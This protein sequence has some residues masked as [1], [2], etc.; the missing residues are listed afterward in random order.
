V[1]PAANCRTDAGAAGYLYG[2]QVSIYPDGHDNSYYEEPDAFRSWGAL[3]AGAVAGTDSAGRPLVRLTVTRPAVVPV[4]FGP[5]CRTP[6]IVFDPASEGDRVDF[7]T[8]ENCLS[9][10]GD[11]YLRYTTVTATPVSGDPSLAISGWS[12]DGAPAPELGTGDLTVTIDPD[13]PA[14]TASMVHCYTV[15]VGI[16]GVTDR[17]NEATGAVRIDG[18][19]CPDGG[20]RYVGGTEVTLTPQILAAG[21]RFNGWDEQRIKP[22][23]PAGGDTGDVTQSARTLVLEGDIR[24]TAGFFDQS[25]CSP[26]TNIGSP[27]LISFEFTGCGPGYYLDDRKQQAAIEGIEASQLTGGKYLSTLRANVHK[28]GALDVYVSI[29]AESPDCNKGDT[30]D[31]EGFAF[32]GPRSGT[33]QCRVSGPVTVDASVCQPVVTDPSFTVAGRPGTTY[34]REW[35]PDTFYVTGPDGYIRGVADYQWGQALPVKPVAGGKYQLAVTSGP[36]A[37]GTNLFAPNTDVLVYASAPSQGFS[38]VGWTGYGPDPVPQTPLHKITDDTAKTLPGSASYL[39]ACH[40]VTF[41]EG[42]HVLADAPYCPGSTPIERSFIFGMSIPVRADY[43]IGDRTIEKFTY[44]VAADQISQDPATLDW[45]GYA[46]VGVGTK[47]TALYQSSADR[48]STEIAKGLKFGAGIVAVVLP[49]VLGTAFP[50]LGMFFAAM[51]TIA[52]ISSF[53]PGGQGA[54]AVFDLLNPTKIT[55]CIARWGFTNAGSPGGQKNIGSMISTGKTIGQAVFTTKDLL[56]F[57]L[58]ILGVAGGAASI[59][60]GLYD[61]GIGGANMVGPQSVEELAGRSTITGCLDD[62]WR[63]TGSNLSRSG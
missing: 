33:V 9:P 35:M 54:A 63:I 41:G 60:Y 25:A 20:D 62:V 17:Y 27:G 58:G 61:A 23:K 26:L 40:T 57:D 10:T 22:E 21:T 52:G 16:D 46:T 3:P 14:Y 15:E 56:T 38:F 43:R 19:K 8:A 24:T 1:Y 4:T 45:Y 5:V 55:G 39:V 34:G 53:I 36:C 42:I 6:D 37:A 13:S 2:T 30:L 31:R 29:D 50:P 18:T 7:D 11:G 51:G 12:V 59:G 28:T 32:L 49:V 44:G 47:V 48:T